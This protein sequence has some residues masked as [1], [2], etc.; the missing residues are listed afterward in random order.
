MYQKELL[1][2]SSTKICFLFDLNLKSLINEIPR[3]DHSNIIFVVLL[4]LALALFFLETV[5]SLT[6]GL[7]SALKNIESQQSVNFFQQLLS[8]FVEL[9]VII[10]AVLNL[11]FVLLIHHQFN[12]VISAEHSQISQIQKQRQIHQ[13]FTVVIHPSAKFLLADLFQVSQRVIFCKLNE[14]HPVFQ[15]EFFGNHNSPKN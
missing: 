12:L 7:N 11:I 13:F 4:F 1:S 6:F 14:F 3:S 10:L 5:L 8:F 9:L 15:F 2:V